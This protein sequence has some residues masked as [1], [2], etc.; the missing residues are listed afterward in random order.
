MKEAES[1]NDVLKFYRYLSDEEK[2]KTYKS[3][4]FRNKVDINNRFTKFEIIEMSPDELVNEL[5]KENPPL[6]QF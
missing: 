2:I 3:E 5:T 6:K 4:W 1:S